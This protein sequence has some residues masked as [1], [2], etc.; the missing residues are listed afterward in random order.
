[1][2]ALLRAL[3]RAS[4]PA[5]LRTLCFALLAGG[6]LTLSGCGSTP[7][8]GGGFYQDDGPPRA[9]P[10]DLER[11]PDA[12]PR[13]EP[14]HPFANRPYTALGRNFTPITD[15]RPIRQRGNASWYGRQFHGNRTAIGERYDMFAMTAAHPTMP[16][17][18][19]ARVTNTRTG[20]SVL[21]RVNDRGP[22]LQDRV[23]DLSYAAAV[24]LGI[25]A[26]GT[27]EVDVVRLTYADIRSGADATTAGT[28]AAIAPRAPLPPVSTPPMPASPV[29]SV[30]APTMTAPATPAARAGGP[31][32]GGPWAVQLGAYSVAA[33][34]EALRERVALLLSAPEAAMLSAAQRAPRVERQDGVFRVLVGAL[35]SREDAQALASQ[36]ET[37]LH[38]DTALYR[39]P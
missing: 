21:V 13:V 27:G 33:N 29:P 8:R 38:R 9:A 23:I 35:A 14:F 5:F 7:K 11:T 26:A 4:S 28:T 2:R 36:I 15:D 6:V 24:R 34:A 20:A 25:A 30:P 22:F 12:V 32:D 31:D 37:L 17:P 1:L 10:R 19:Y 3:L 16:L 18:S 39:W